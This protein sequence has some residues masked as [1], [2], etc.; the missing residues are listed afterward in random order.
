M[1]WYL[2]AIPIVIAIIIKLVF[3]YTQK[4]QIDDQIICSVCR[5]KYNKKQNGCPKCGVGRI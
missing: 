2:I 1:V 3:H 4:N 5:A